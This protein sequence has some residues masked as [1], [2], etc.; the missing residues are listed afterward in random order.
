MSHRSNAR[1]SSKPTT[2]RGDILRLVSGAGAAQ[3]IGVLAAPILTRLYAPEAFGEAAAFISIVAIFGVIACLRYELA[4]VLPDNDVDAVNLFA[5]SLL[6]TIVVT[7]VLGSVFW[8]AS[9]PLLQALRLSQLLPYAWLI[10]LAV[11]FQGAFLALN[12]W[13]SRARLY[14][15]L[16]VVRVLGSATTAS[17]QIGAG[18]AGHA[19]SGSM[20]SA[21][22]GGQVA[23]VALLG[24]QALR[25]DGRFIAKNVCWQRML[26]GIKRYRKFPLISTWSSLLNTASWQLPVLL[27]GIFFSPA[28]VGFYALGFRLLQ[29]P[30]NFVGGAISQVFLQRA[31]VAKNAGELS[32]LVGSLTQ[33]LVTIGLFPMLTLSIVGEDLYTLVFGH[34]WAQAGVYTQILAIWAFVWFVSSPLARLF[35]VLE[36]QELSLIINIVI[37][38]S[39]LASLIIGGLYKDVYLALALF[40]ISGVAL[41]GYQALLVCRCAGVPALVPWAILGKNL[42]AFAPFGAV[43]LVLS[44]M[45]AGS[46]TMVAVAIA[47]LVIF[48]LLV[49]RQEMARRG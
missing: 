38:L 10:P 28:V 35:F 26:D 30:M 22:V 27:L 25:E 7:A 19:T 47:S 11:F 44:F 40:A 41:Y 32:P 24:G 16:S 18:L 49:L 4:I 6:A 14:K 5:A 23:A 42:L 3:L 20:I 8:F 46:L 17:V 48:A 31:A 15:R 12:Y 37:F 13:N 43:L 29:M 39:R 45:D 36:R 1:V 21:K 34:E 2:F 9:E 33:R